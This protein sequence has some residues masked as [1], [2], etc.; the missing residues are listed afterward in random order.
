MLYIQHTNL[1]GTVID[2]AF[3]C[4]RSIYTNH[5]ECTGEDNSQ[6]KVWLVKNHATSLY[7]RMDHIESS[8]YF[9]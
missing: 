2:E 1:C 8:K 9:A 3:L 4:L 7:E 6:G 5:I